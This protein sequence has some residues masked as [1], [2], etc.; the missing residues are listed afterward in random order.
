MPMASCRDLR[1]MML[2]SELIEGD[3]VSEEFN[4]VHPGV[5]Q[6]TSALSDDLEAVTC[7]ADAASRGGLPDHQVARL[8][9]AV[10]AGNGWR[11]VGSNLSDRRAGDASGKR[12]SVATGVVGSQVKPVGVPL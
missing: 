10:E 4:E 8:I 1:D 6:A 11:N 5:G 2:S 9:I 3:S 7:V 12:S